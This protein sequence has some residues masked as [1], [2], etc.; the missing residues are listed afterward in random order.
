M[1]DLGQRFQLVTLAY[2]RNTKN[3]RINK[4]AP[5]LEIIISHLIGTL[6]ID[7]T[8]QNQITRIP[9]FHF[10]AFTPAASFSQVSLA[11]PRSISVLSLRK[12]GLSTPA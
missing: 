6:K 8:Y 2:Q 10:K 9:Q 3:V 4:I 7:Y 1:K 11:S 5:G 12:T